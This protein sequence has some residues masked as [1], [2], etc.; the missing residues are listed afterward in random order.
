MI[1]SKPSI[2]PPQPLPADFLSRSGVPYRGPSILL[3]LELLNTEHACSDSSTV[4]K[5][6][7]LP[8]RE[9]RGRNRLPDGGPRS[10]DGRPQAG[11][12]QQNI[13]G[14]SDPG[15]GLSEALG[16]K[17]RPFLQ[18]LTFGRQ[19]REDEYHDHDHNA[20]CYLHAPCRGPGGLQAACPGAISFQ[21]RLLRTFRSSCTHTLL[22]WCRCQG[23]RDQAGVIA[24]RHDQAAV[25]T[26]AHRR[27]RPTNRNALGKVHRGKPAPEESSANVRI[28]TLLFSAT[29]GSGRS[30]SPRESSSRT[31]SSNST[32]PS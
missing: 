21:H 27:P 9:K 19:P 24:R 23:R 25:Q 2:R 4:G 30:S 29:S 31:Q 6:R 14:V 20:P 26:H 8:Q 22:T 28:F 32:T 12:K 15:G 10:A 7:K 3:E 1:P 17:A 5:F 11:R 18:E 16:G 13:L